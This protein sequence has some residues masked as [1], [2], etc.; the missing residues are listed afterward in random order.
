LKKLQQY[1]IFKISTTQLN[2]SNYN[3]QISFIEAQK[4]AKIISLGDSQMLRTLRA[5]KN[6]NIDIN[7]I[8][9]LLSEKRKI[10]KR[11]HNKE[12]L[13]LLLEVE[14]KL[15]DLLFVPEIISVFVDDIKHYKYIGKNGFIIKN[16][17][18]LLVEQVKQEETMHY[19]L[20]KNMKKRCIL[21]LTM[22]EKIL[23]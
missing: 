18:G 17:L 21:F 9:L 1:Y 23:K 19:L 8:D 7:E 10:K 13:K 12:N 16:M 6:I 14:K 15:T 20:T 11:S 4:S 2:H 3:L 5:I 22:T